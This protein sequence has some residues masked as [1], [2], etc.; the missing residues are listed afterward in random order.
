LFLP[1]LCDEEKAILFQS[2]RLL[3]CKLSDPI[4]VAITIAMKRAEG[5]LSIRA[6]S[7]YSAGLRA[8]NFDVSSIRFR[9]LRYAI[10]LAPHI[11]TIRRQIESLE[12]LDQVKS[13]AIAM[14]AVASLTNEDL[15][16]AFAAKMQAMINAG[17]FD[18]AN[19]ADNKVA[20]KK[21]ISALIRV[22]DFYN[23]AFEAAHGMSQSPYTVL[24]R[25]VIAQLESRVGQVRPFGMV[26]LSLS[27][28]KVGGPRSI[29][30]A[31]DERIAKMLDYALS[32]CEL[33]SSPAGAN[34]R[35]DPDLEDSEDKVYRSNLPTLSFIA[36]F[37][38]WKRRG[39]D[40]KK[41]APIVESAIKGPFFRQ[42][43]DLIYSILKRS[44]DSS[45]ATATAK[46]ESRDEKNR[47]VGMFFNRAVTELDGN[48]IEMTRLSQQYFALRGSI[49]GK[50]TRPCLE[51]EE[52]MAEM[53][54]R[55][56]M[57]AP[58]LSV[59]ATQLR[60]ILRTSSG[61]EAVTPALMQKLRDMM[62][63]AD[64]LSIF[65]LSGVVADYFTFT[66]T[67]ANKSRSNN[68]S[69][70]SSSITST[71][72]LA[73]FVGEINAM[74]EA[75]TEELLSDTCDTS[76]NLWELKTLLESAVLRRK[77]V[78]DRMISALADKVTAHLFSDEADSHS[79]L[80]AFVCENLRILC[81][82]APVS[83][84]IC[85]KVVDW[86]LA[87]SSEV[88]FRDALIILRFLTN[89]SYDLTGHPRAPAFLKMCQKLVIHNVE[90]DV[91][92]LTSVTAATLLACHRSLSG[93]VIEKIF[94][95]KFLDGFD[96]DIKELSGSEDR[97]LRWL[98]S[99]MELNRTVCILHPES[100]VPWFHEKFCQ[101]Y[102][103]W[104]LRRFQSVGGQQHSTSS[105]SSN[106]AD[107]GGGGLAEDVYTVLSQVLGGGK[108][109]KD[110]TRTQYYHPINFEFWMHRKTGQFYPLAEIVGTGSDGGLLSAS[111]LDPNGDYKK[112]A[113]LL[114]APWEPKGDVRRIG[115]LQMHELETLGYDVIPINDKVWYHMSM[116]T[117]KDKKQYI[118][119]LV[120]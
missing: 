82:K 36:Y 57:Q 8:G 103:P 13:L 79:S 30:D 119:S 94:C 4:M 48:W 18:K 87:R 26:I 106:Y 96:A 97:K 114:P 51:F 76:A 116:S 77:I 112:F 69:S 78:D 28:R 93:E 113:V 95:P 27:L 66:S 22:L 9:N 118:A 84:D 120:N 41:Y 105:S 50:P 19:L 39:S 80:V 64:P 44:W 91:Y 40:I 29:W 23:V 24:C 59:F 107:C 31:V 33:S 85:D 46:R 104:H 75:R 86:T 37:N 42:H 63:E 34:Q 6:L 17:V 117:L 21:A 67:I 110:S 108:Y 10:T 92:T 7:Y 74:L 81:I 3:D 25:S 16:M 52:R 111:K 99:L 88:P 90:S 101:E 102:W 20:E 1:D 38:R 43:A 65:M 98:W 2:L 70:S 5:R 47:I 54:A 55:D 45:G 15:H 49:V 53:S 12:T 14:K 56:I 72:Q 83:T 100:R 115:L 89:E 35:G 61:V 60:F 62:F 58:F 109:L 32:G 73:Q 68:S 71:S 11:P